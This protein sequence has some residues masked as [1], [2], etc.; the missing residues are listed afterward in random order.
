MILPGY[1]RAADELVDVEL[2]E[3]D[4]R[5]VLCVFDRTIGA[6]D[7]HVEYQASETLRFGYSFGQ[8]LGKLGAHT[9]GSHAILELTIRVIRSIRLNFL[10]DISRAFAPTIKWIPTLLTIRSTPIRLSMI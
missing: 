2:V 1:L 3:L 6:M 10:N 5:S 4:G 7:L 9:F 8:Q